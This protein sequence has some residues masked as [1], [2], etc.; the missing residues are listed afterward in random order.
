[1]QNSVANVP[2]K[3]HT[4]NTLEYNSGDTIRVAGRKMERSVL[5]KKKRERESD[6]D[7]I[8]FTAGTNVANE[9][10]KRDTG[11]RLRNKRRDL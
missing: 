11:N 2:L 1:M 4:E 10:L 5:K 9:P 6:A 8:I 3:K 7:R